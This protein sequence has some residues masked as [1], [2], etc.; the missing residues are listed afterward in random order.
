M[1][2][3][4]K[5]RVAIHPGD[6]IR[7]FHFRDRRRKVYWLYHCVIV[8]DGAMDMVP[9]QQLA[10]GKNDGGSCWVKSLADINGMIAQPE[11]LSGVVFPDD[12]GKVPMTPSNNPPPDTKG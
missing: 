2:L 5:N 6:L 9:V 1:I 3:H 7:T 12:R 11:V 10:T 4:D 8:R